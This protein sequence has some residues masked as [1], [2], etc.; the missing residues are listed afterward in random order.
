MTEEQKKQYKKRCRQYT[1][2]WYKNLENSP[3]N[4]TEKELDEMSK[5]EKKK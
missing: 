4:F 1:K 2:D 5:K 3:A